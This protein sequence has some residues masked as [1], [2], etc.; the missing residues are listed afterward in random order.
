MVLKMLKS[1]S[2]N[3]EGGEEKEVAPMTKYKAKPRRWYKGTVGE[4]EPINLTK[5]E[6]EMEKTYKKWRKY[7]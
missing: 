4:F 5:F 1:I 2:E 7:L 3:E 6:K